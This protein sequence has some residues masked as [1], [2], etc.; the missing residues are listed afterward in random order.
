MTTRKAIERAIE[1]I[2]QPIETSARMLVDVTH[3]PDDVLIAWGEWI[4]Q[5]PGRR[6]RTA[7]VGALREWR[8]AHPTHHDTNALDRLISLVENGIE[9]TASVALRLNPPLYGAGVCAHWPESVR[10]VWDAYFSGQEA[11]PAQVLAALRAWHASL[12]VNDD[13]SR[14]WGWHL[15]SED[16]TLHGPFSTRAEAVSDIHWHAA[17]PGH[18]TIGRCEPRLVT[19]CGAERIRADTEES[20]AFDGM[21]NVKV[22]LRSGAEEAL[23][24]W[25]AKYLVVDSHPWELTDVET[26][27]GDE[28][29]S[30][31]PPEQAVETPQ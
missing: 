4:S 11:S 8:R 31:D 29:V 18:V 9:V 14:A 3:F 21:L 22:S 7:L 10:S 15:D 25:M 19:S 13:D 5:P 16:A 20:L 27:W 12:P 28:D 17:E 2:S 1:L 6:E 30:D 23:D 24:E 26:W